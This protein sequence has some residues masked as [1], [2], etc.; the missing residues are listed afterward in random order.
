[1]RCHSDTPPSSVRDGRAAP[2]RQS[3][4]DDREGLREGFDDESRGSREIVPKVRDSGS[5][6]HLTTDPTRYESV[7]GPNRRPFPGGA[8]N[9]LGTAADAPA[10]RSTHASTK[11]MDRAARQRFAADRLTRDL[12]FGN[13][14]HFREWLTRSEE[15]IASNILAEGHPDLPTHPPRSRRESSRI[16]SALP[17]RSSRILTAMPEPWETPEGRACIDRWVTDSMSRLNRYQG[18]AQFNSRKPWSINKYGVLEGHHPGGPVSNGAPDDFAQYNYDR[19]RYMWA[20]WIPAGANAT[21]IWP[22]WNAAGVAALHA[23]VQ[24]CLG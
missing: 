1:M 16:E 17:P 4:P 6:R 10:R 5:A 18:N 11:V 15:R 12:M 22:E 19:Y 2:R 13:R 23:Y 20:M 8:P 7:E 3:A 14:R 24:R 9:A 21:W